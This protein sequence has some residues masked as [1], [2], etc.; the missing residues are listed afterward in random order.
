MTGGSFTA[1]TVTVKVRANWL[2]A[3]SAAVTVMTAEPF[4]LVLGRKVSVPDGLGLVWEMDGL[5]MRAGLLETAGS[6]ILFSSPRT[7][8]EPAPNDL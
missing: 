4:A 6:G 7:I 1:V 5:G 3:V 2:P 8:L